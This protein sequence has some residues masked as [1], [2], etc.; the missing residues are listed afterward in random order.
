M[1]LKD[2]VTITHMKKRYSGEI[3]DEIFN[4]IYGGL[5]ENEKESKSLLDKQRK[6]FK[7]VEPKKEPD[8]VKDEP[9]NAGG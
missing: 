4:L 1:K 7:W 6:K 5:G 9:E 3:K 8:K 2:G